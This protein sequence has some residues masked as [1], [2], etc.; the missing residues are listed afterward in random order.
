MSTKEDSAGDGRWAG[1]M[2]IVGFVFVATAQVTKNRFG[3]VRA[4]IWPDRC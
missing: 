2:A 1:M 3:S 4:S